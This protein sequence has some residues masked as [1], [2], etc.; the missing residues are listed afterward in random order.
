[1]GTANIKYLSSLIQQLIELRN[2][3]ESDDHGVLRAAQPAFDRACHLLIDAAIVSALESRQIPHGCAS[4]DS[5]GGIRIEWVRDSASVH[6]IVPASDKRGEYVY[7]EEGANYG[8]EPATAETL[9]RW[10]VGVDNAG[11]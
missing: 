8:T 3:P 10:L 5:E 2:E 11:E 6:L 4:T 1:V 7:H 9:A